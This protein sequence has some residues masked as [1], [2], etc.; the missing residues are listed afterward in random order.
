[1]L[2]VFSGKNDDVAGE[3]NEM[4]EVQRAEA[5]QE[6]WVELVPTVSSRPLTSCRSY[7]TGSLCPKLSS[8]L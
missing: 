7:S 1:V 2:R 3:I 8:T 6:K 5:N 4:L